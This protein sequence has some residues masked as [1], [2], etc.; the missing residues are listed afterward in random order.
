MTSLDDVRVSSAAAKQ[1]RGRAGRV[2]EGLCVHIYP[3]DER[4]DAY[5]EPEVRRSRY[6]VITPLLRA[7]S[8]R[9][10][11]FWRAPVT[12]LSPLTLQVRRVPLEQLVMR[13]KALRLPGLAAQVCAELPEPPAAE[14]VLSSVEALQ[15]LGA[16]TEDE[17]L[18]PLGELLA[19][20]PLDPRLGK[21]IL[22]G[23]CFD[24]LDESLTIAAA[25]ASRSP[26]MSP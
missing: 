26:F 11:D 1:R 14:A 4:L 20:L 25:L 16:L 10:R 5:T 21:L 18:T 24:V 23:S 22:L 7:P 8:P 3:S 15:G 19:K 6:L 12:W 2:A 9:R 13:A 17:T